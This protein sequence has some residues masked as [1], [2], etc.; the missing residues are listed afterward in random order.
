MVGRRS[1]PRQAPELLCR[2]PTY[3]QA[4]D[5]WSCGV[6]CFL[7]CTGTHPFPNADRPNPSELRERIRAGSL[8]FPG[9]ASEQVGG[10]AGHGPGAL[11]TPLACGAR[12]LDGSAKISCNACCGRIPAYATA[13]PRRCCTHGSR[14]QHLPG[15]SP[16]VCLTSAAAAV[17]HRAACGHSSSRSRARCGQCWK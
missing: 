13:R 9:A 6:I 5:M 14:T 7:L 8:H 11:L 15:L 12:W 17:A 3:S 16:Q 4:V 10:T 1:Q 2:R